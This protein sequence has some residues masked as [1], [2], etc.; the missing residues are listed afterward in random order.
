M[1]KQIQLN[2]KYG[3]YSDSTG[4]DIADDF[5]IEIDFKLEELPTA[6]NKLLLPNQ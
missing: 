2:E 5:T 6:N 3:S 4:L 1:E